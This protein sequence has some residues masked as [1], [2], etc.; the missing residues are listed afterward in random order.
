MR[1]WSKLRQVAFLV[2][3]VGALMPGVVQA[4]DPICPVA[5]CAT[6]RDWFGS[7]W[8]YG[9]CADFGCTGSYGNCQPEGGGTP[10]HVCVCPP[11]QT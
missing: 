3:L 7:C 1:I 6:E 2:I 8:T 9:S 4:E 5:E 10:A 11:L